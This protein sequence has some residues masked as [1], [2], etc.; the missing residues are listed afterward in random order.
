[1]HVKLAWF[2][3]LW[4]V[5]PAL[6]SWNAVGSAKDWREFD[7]R[8]CSTLPC[9]AH[10]LAL[11]RVVWSL[12]EGVTLVCECFEMFCRLLPAYCCRWIGVNSMSRGSRHFEW[13]FS[14]SVT[15]C[16][17][18]V[19]WMLHSCNRRS[20][21]CALWNG[22]VPLTMVAV[23]FDLPCCACLVVAGL[24]VS[25]FVVAGIV[26]LVLAFLFW[27]VVVWEVTNVFVKCMMGELVQCLKHFLV[28]NWPTVNKRE[29]P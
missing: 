12:D 16:R 15:A 4:T 28:F 29:K 5:V 7:K 10:W 1:M 17:S 22:L 21:W 26:V 27:N 23:M 8:T 2:C 9:N 6:F 20:P 24:A 3:L 19:Y 18:L 13:Q 11:S 25:R 14:S